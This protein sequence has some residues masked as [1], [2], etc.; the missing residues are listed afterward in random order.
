[1]SSQGCLFGRGVTA[2]TPAT[3]RPEQREGTRRAPYVSKVL[4]VLSRKVIHVEQGLGEALR[5]HFASYGFQATA[6]PLSD[7]PMD[8]VEI[9]GRVSADSVQAALDEWQP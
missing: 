1:M 7:T 5:Q 9:V 3:R 6:G 2:P 8:R 4:S